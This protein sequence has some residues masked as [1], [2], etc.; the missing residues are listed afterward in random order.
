ML[1]FGGD[2]ATKSRAYSTT[3]GALRA[4]RSA[5]MRRANA[6]ASSARPELGPPEDE[7]ETVLVVG[8]WTYGGTGWRTAADAALA[9][10]AADA[11]RSRR[12]VAADP[13]A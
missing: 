7:T 9:L 5:A 3:F 8:S 12:P 2:F 6:S 4:A 11:A 13:A 10:A 1:G